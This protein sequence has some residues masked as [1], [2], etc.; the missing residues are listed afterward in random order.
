MQRARTITFGFAVLTAV[1]L[2]A[3]P[4]AT[5]PYLAIILGHVAAGFIL[6]GLLIVTRPRSAG[7]IVTA[8]GALLGIVLTWTG[9]SRPFIALLYAHIGLS[10]L[11]LIILLAARRRRPALSFAV[12]FVAA[13]AVG[14]SAWVIREVRWRNAYRIRNPD[15]P[16]Q[17]QAAEGDG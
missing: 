5:I 9:A 15:M 16:P 17:S 7:W 1:Y 14:A 13:L 10:A 8:G 2:Y 4:S 6:A 11:G 12:F 3:F